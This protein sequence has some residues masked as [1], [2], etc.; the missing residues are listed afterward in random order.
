MVRPTHYN[1]RGITQ[2]YG[3]AGSAIVTGT[4]S[5]APPGSS[6]DPAGTT[7]KAPVRVA[8]TTN[9]T[10]A[11]AYENGDTVDGVVLATG[12]RILI[13]DQTDGTE[14]GIYVVQASGAPV[15]AS[16][17]DDSSEVVGAIIYVIAGTING[18]TTWVSTNLTPPTIGF[19]FDALT[20]AEL[21]SPA[22]I[23]G[24]GF[25]GEI[26]ISDTHATPLVFADLIQNEAQDDLVYSDT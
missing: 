3:G 25:V 15:R 1:P 18:T 20:F 21:I 11:T 2:L 12:D 24:F 8:T 13:K 17:L 4:S 6:G 5:T 14:N 16:D 9:G 7:W 19:G 22:A 10:L 26:L 23:A